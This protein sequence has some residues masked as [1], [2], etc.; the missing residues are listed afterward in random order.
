M[1][2]VLRIVL[3][4]RPGSLGA[5]ATALGKAGA[6]ILAM[7]IVERSVGHAVDDL[8]VDLPP[9]RQPDS[10]ITAAES[11]EGVRV[12]S[13]RPD[14]GIAET[15]RE[16]ELVEAL[17]L[18]PKNA[19]QTL[20]DMLP[21]VLRAGWAI[22]VRVV[23]GRAELVVGGGGVPSLNGIVPG[24]APVTKATGLDGEAHWVPADWK[25]LGT[26]MAV[27]PLGSPDL[28]ILV[29]RP[30]GPALRSSEVARLGHL[31]G[32]TVVVAGLEGK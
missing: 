22:V 19:L 30:G 18:D 24:W 4:D 10:L 29:G 17:A 20:A 13:V 26:E 31:A 8:V 16:W 1:S 32:L 23:D 2:Y 28:A 3:P 9:N 5:V 11:V 25:T 15:H 21:R 27:A 7:D 6:D 12:E 14:P